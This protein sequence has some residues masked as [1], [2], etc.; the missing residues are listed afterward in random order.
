MKRW[1]DSEWRQMH[2]VSVSKKRGRESDW[3]HRQRPQGNE[4]KSASELSNRSWSDRGQKQK[5]RL[6]RWL[7]SKP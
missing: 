6:Q 1:S 7:R 4:R 2:S 3:K 5:N